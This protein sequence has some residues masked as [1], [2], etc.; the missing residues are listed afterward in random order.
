MVAPDLPSPSPAIDP[1]ARLET[2]L[3]RLESAYAF[4]STVSVGSEVAVRAAGRWI[5]STSEFEILSDGARTIYRIVPP[6]AW[7]RKPAADSWTTLEGEVPGLPPLDALRLP[8]TTE[9]VGTGD[10]TVALRALF[11]AT[12]LGQAAD[13]PIPV[14][15]LLRQDGS[16][17]ATYSV[18]VAGTDTVTRTT[19]RPLADAQPIEPPP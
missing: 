12:D 1:S 18:E 10:G 4:E 13:L 7:V 3:D 14:T 2:A 16:V 8:M 11:E 9:L 17:E 6:R 15:L 19:M 5:A